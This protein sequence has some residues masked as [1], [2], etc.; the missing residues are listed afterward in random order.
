MSTNLGILVVNHVAE[1]ARVLHLDSI[2]VR[3]ASTASR[4]RYCFT[5]PPMQNMIEEDGRSQFAA[6]LKSVLARLEPKPH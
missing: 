1:E 4:T 5:L 2:Q 6:E 3:T